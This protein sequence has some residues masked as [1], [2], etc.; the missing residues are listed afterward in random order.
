MSQY[1]GKIGSFK[2]ERGWIVCDKFTEEVWIESTLPLIEGDIVNFEI[3]KDSNI[4][5]ACE[6]S[7]SPLSY[8]DN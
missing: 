1:Q 7:L 6:I 8:D 4:L 2:N 5:E 3:M